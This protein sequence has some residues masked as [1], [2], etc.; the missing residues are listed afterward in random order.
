MYSELKIRIESTDELLEIIDTQNGTKNVAKGFHNEVIHE[1]KRCINSWLE[2]F[3]DNIDKYYYDD[4][5]SP[6]DYGLKID[7]VEEKMMFVGIK[8][9][10][11]QWEFVHT[12]I[13]KLGLIKWQ[14]KSFNEKREFVANAVTTKHLNT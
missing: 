13:A 1:L 11:A 7:F 5:D 8:L 12:E 10:D 2:D 6:E 4:M 3:P 14:E 9:N